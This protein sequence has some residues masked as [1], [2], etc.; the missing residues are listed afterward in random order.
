VRAETNSSWVPFCCS[1]LAGKIGDYKLCYQSPSGSD[2]VE[3]KSKEGVIEIKAPSWNFDPNPAV[4]HSLW[5][6]GW[7]SGPNGP[8]WST[9]Q[10]LETT[11]TSQDTI[12]VSWMRLWAQKRDVWEHLILYVRILTMYSKLRSLILCRTYMRNDC[13]GRGTR[14]QP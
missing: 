7:S 8:Q 10:V 5:T 1:K 3:Q 2:S 4:W 12:T 11:T 9:V 6:A 14:R 13:M